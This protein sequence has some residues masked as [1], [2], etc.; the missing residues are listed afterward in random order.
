MFLSHSDKTLAPEVLWAQRTDELFVTIN[1]SDVEDPKIEL[2]NEQ[3]S[4]SGRSRGGAYAVTFPFFKEVNPDE[5]K[6]SVTARNISLVIAKKEKGQEYWPRL[7]KEKTKTHWLK[8]DFSKWKDEDEDDEVAAPGF[9]DMDLSQF[10]GMGGMGGMPG[11]GGMEGLG[12]MGGMGGMNGM[13]FGAAG[14]DFS[15]A[16]SVVRSGSWNSLLSFSHFHL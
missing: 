6:Q 10:Q 3:L 13:D 16:V 9:G 7:M 5:S 4:V 2:T 15:G 11:M 14:M 12:G 1:L 8:T